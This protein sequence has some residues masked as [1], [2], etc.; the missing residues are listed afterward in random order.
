MRVNVDHD[1]NESLALNF[2]L[3]LQPFDDVYRALSFV[4][5]TAIDNG[6]LQ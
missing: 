1:K 5:Q 3:K 4:Q 6:D 2:E